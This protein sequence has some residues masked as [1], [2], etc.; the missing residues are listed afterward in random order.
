MLDNHV[1]YFIPVIN[2]DGSALVE[3]H[4]KSDKVIL[5]KRKNNNPKYRGS[6]SEEDVGTDLNRNYGI[7]W[8][9]LNSTNHTELCGDYWPGDEA[10]SEP[11]TRAFRDFVAQH[12]Q[13][14]KFIINCHT[15]GNQFV[16]PFNGRAPNDIDSRAPGYLAIFQDINKNAPFPTGVLSGNS[17]EVIGDEMG[18]DA[19][20]YMLA[21]FGIPAVTA[22]MGFFGQYIKDW[23]C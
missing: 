13:D 19:D 15:S 4:W 8:T 18:G 17:H 2:A 7:D 3:R 23:R 5:N 10:F 6:C 14:I 16:W 12:K 11:E 21:T 20:D 22:E 9:P 1:F